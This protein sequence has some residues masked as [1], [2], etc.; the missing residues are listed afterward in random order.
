MPR[1][2]QESL[3]VVSAFQ[4]KQKTPNKAKN[5]TSGSGLFVFGIHV[6][7]RFRSRIFLDVHQRP[8]MRDVER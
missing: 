7:G 1:E 6:L 5:P 3:F 8:V 2:S 4:S